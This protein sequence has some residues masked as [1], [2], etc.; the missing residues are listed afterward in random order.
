MTNAME[1]LT[2]PTARD[3]F[4]QR[5]V[6]RYTAFKES[7]C[8]ESYAVDPPN[9]DELLEFE[10]RWPD[11][12]GDNS[13]SLRPEYQSRKPASDV[14]VLEPGDGKEL[15][16]DARKWRKEYLKDV[17]ANQKPPVPKDVCSRFIRAQHRTDAQLDIQKADIRQRR[18]RVIT[19]AIATSS[20]GF[21]DWAALVPDKG[22]SNASA[23]LPSLRAPAVHESGGQRYLDLQRSVPT[24]YGYRSNDPVIQHISPYEFCSQWQVESSKKPKADGKDTEHVC[25]TAAGRAKCTSRKGSTVKLDAGVDYKIKQGGSDWLPLIECDKVLRSRH[26]YIL[27]RLPRPRVPVL[28]GDTRIFGDD[29]V[30]MLANVL[31][32]PWTL[33][34]AAKGSASAAVPHIDDL[35][36]DGKWW[37]ALEQHIVSGG[38]TSRKLLESMMRFL[39]R[40]VG[41]DDGEE[42]DGDDD[43]Q[44]MQRAAAFWGSDGDARRCKVSRFASAVS[45]PD[46]AQSEIRKQRREAKES[47]GVANVRAGR[48]PTL[49]VQEDA[50]EE[51]VLAA[52]AQAKERC[53]GKRATRGQCRFVD[54]VQKR[55]LEERKS[56]GEPLKL[57]VHGRPGVG[58]STVLKAILAAFDEIG[59]RDEVAVTAHMATMAE[60]IGGQTL[61]SLFGWKVGQRE[62]EQQRNERRKKVDV[63][64]GRGG[65]RGLGAGM[66]MKLAPSTHE[67]FR[68]WRT[69]VAVGCRRTL[70]SAKGA[71]DF[72]ESSG[73]RLD[74][75]SA[76]HG[77]LCDPAALG[78]SAGRAWGQ[79]VLRGF[80]SIVELTEQVR[81][82][83]ARFSEML[84]RLRSGEGLS[85]DDMKL[86]TKR[87]LRDPSTD[88]AQRWN[89]KLGLYSEFA[90][91][92]VICANNDQRSQI[93]LERTRA[94]ARNTN[95]SLLWSVARDTLG[96]G[97][98][99]QNRIRDRKE[100]GVKMDKMTWLQHNDRRCGFLAGMLALVEGM[101]VSLTDHVDKGK[102][103]LK[104]TEG[105]LEGLW[106]D[107]EEPAQSHNAD[108]ECVLRKVPI[109]A[110][111]RFPHLDDPIKI[112]IK[113]TRWCLNPS[114]RS[115][116]QQFWGKTL[117][118][119]IVDL[120]IPRG[121]EPIAA[122]VALSRL[123]RLSDL[124]VF[125]SFDP[126]P[127]HYKKPGIDDVLRTIRHNQSR[128]QR[129]CSVCKEEL[130]VEMFSADMFRRGDDARKCISCSKR[131]QDKARV[132]RIA[133]QS[134]I[135]E[136]L[137]AGGKVCSECG[138]AKPNEGYAD[139]ELNQ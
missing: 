18:G 19:R 50:T 133:H 135:Q 15:R 54:V 16:R 115:K 113:S 139:R 28:A 97:T 124:L 21:S 118:K 81:C 64:G 98:K 126:M 89:E 17:R 108:G 27:R 121:R 11:Y 38:V 36:P 134:V 85:S 39:H 47:E 55:V 132:V 57:L 5:V 129:K 128:L 71:M 46:S 44:G 63:C 102:Q 131:S 32:R 25:V 103:L 10:G 90:D 130:A 117:R 87:T 22:C 120:R 114:Q 83:D 109:A 24:A 106:L 7:A 74:P 100:E 93:N 88:S 37:D 112:G 70:G 48:D 51:E 79:M 60:Q 40:R 125:A 75:P 62:T 92:P 8:L 56:K 127:L 122:Y 42:Q 26:S 137:W 77:G 86:L 72:L 68:G 94:Y 45:A 111:V 9:E 34:P 61:F 101:P 136:K 14:H 116:R 65:G 58:K 82:D 84:D 66:A 99:G 67:T 76:G 2:D 104:G 6:E 30:A 96:K 80:D 69:N 23:R 95:R 35:A 20:M 110:I 105:I 41:K 52:F 13:L 49:C 4:K 53:G 138:V 123:R 59:M 3:D 31:F 78:T 29:G 12:P 91:A 43:A 1:V 119:A 73:Q 33:D 107:P